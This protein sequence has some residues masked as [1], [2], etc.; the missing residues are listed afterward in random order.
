MSLSVMKVHKEKMYINLR[1]NILRQGYISCGI[2]CIRCSVTTCQV[3]VHALIRNLQVFKTSLMENPNQ[4]LNELIFSVI[5]M[6]LI[7]FLLKEPGSKHVKKVRFLQNKSCSFLCF[8]HLFLPSR[9]LNPIRIFGDR[10][11][12]CTIV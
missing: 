1:L 7:K 3:L 5:L 8:N 10:H 4:K 6:T 11:Y 12:T 9:D 2:F